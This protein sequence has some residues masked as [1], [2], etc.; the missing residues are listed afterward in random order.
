MPGSVRRPLLTG[1]SAIA[2]TSAALVAPAL[3]APA[4]SS[5]YVMLVSGTGGVRSTWEVTNFNGLMEA[6]SGG[7][8]G[9]VVTAVPERPLQECPYVSDAR[10]VAGLGVNDAEYGVDGTSEDG[11]L[12]DAFD[13]GL[14]FTVDGEQVVAP[15]TWEVDSDEDGDASIPRAV[16]SGP[17]RVG[18][19]D[20]VVEYRAMRTQQVLRSTVWLTNPGTQPITVPFEVASNV[21]SD[22]DTVIVGSSTGDDVVSGADRWV[23]TSGTAD[24]WSEVVVTHVLGGP[25]AMTSPDAVTP[26]VF[27]CY[28][29]DG[30]GASFSVALP[31][32]ATRGLM[33]LNELS[34]TGEGALASAERFGRTPAADDELVSDL[35][36]AQRAQIV[37]W[38]FG[39]SQPNTPTPPPPPPAQPSDTTGP[40]SQVTGSPA[41]SRTG[42]WTVSYEATDTGD[43]VRDVQLWVKRPGDTAFTQAASDAQGQTDGRFEFGGATL[44]G[45]YEFYTVATDRAGNT[46]AAPAVADARTT[47]DTTAPTVKVK[48]GKHRPIAF[49]ISQQAPLALRMRVSEAAT[50]SF[51]IRRHGETVRAFGPAANA[52][53]LVVQDW[54]GRADGARVG[55]GRYKLVTRATDPAG[56]TRVVRTPIHVTR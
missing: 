18:G 30:I 54:N 55:A 27:D 45:D 5:D 46:E 41:W 12:G 16:T 28:T 43:G 15:E 38:A 56:N 22:E 21:G 37:N 49:D 11:R 48:M 6:G 44:E 7:G 33:F 29:T 34:P 35:S 24:S 50:T 39:G 10:E 36:A 26:H 20:T 19:V 47:V 8:G 1:L 4:A 31:P 3:A 53:G 9:E 25:D 13:F 23:A 40:T 52:A 17:V 14:I 51:A 32:G 42:A 2:V